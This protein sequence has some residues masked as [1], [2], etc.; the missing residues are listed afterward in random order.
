M[1]KFQD[2]TGQRFGHLVVLSFVGRIKNQSVW[3]CRCDC[4]EETQVYASNLKS[5]GTRS[6]GCGLVKVEDLTGRRFGKLTVLERAERNASGK[7]R[8]RCRCDC[9]KERIVI[10]TLLRNGRV[11]S[12]GCELSAKQRLFQTWADMITRCE[13]PSVRCWKYYGGKG[14]AVCDEWH[15]FSNFE[16]WAMCNGYEGGLT[17]DRID[18][19]GN[20]EPSNCRFIPLEENQQLGFS[21]AHKHAVDSGRY[22]SN[23][24]KLYILNHRETPAKE[25][26]KKFNRCVATIYHVWN[27]TTHIYKE[28]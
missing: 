19:E 26:A 10:G 12:C 25:L 20:Y 3:K 21:M 8:W 1:S 28:K 11:I 18:S 27:G 13:N 22:L 17:I 7:I 15:F 24:Q 4:G 23:E 9:G 5:G 14:I 2:L 6:C 16:A